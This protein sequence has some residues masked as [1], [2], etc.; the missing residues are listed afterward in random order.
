VKINIWVCRPFGAAFRSLAGLEMT[1]MIALAL[2]L[3]LTAATFTARAAEQQQP[4]NAQTT[5]PLEPRSCQQLHEETNKCAPVCAAAISASSPG[6][7]RGVSVIRN[8]Y[9][10][11]WD[12]ATAGDRDAE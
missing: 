8:D 5:A 9:R 12:R 2:G 11:Y 7:R 1:K 3:V 6:W 10:K 4:P